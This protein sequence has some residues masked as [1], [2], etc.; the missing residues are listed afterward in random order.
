MIFNKIKKNIF[1][2]KNVKIILNQYYCYF[3]NIYH[4]I[5]FIFPFPIYKF[6][7]KILGLQIGSFSTLDFKV[8]IKY[9]WLVTIKNYVSIQRNCEFYSGLSGNSRISIGNGCR[10]GP[11]VK[12]YASSHKIDIHKK[13]LGQYFYEKHDDL[14]IMVHSNVWIGAN[15]IKLPGVTIQKNSVIAAGSVLTKNC[16]ANVLVAGCP[17]KVIKSLN[18]K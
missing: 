4:L 9:P 6:F 10:I 5:A 16:P 14:P 15:S 11:N 8:F 17:A 12:F 13:L 1:N 2:N 18:G 7:F 3:I